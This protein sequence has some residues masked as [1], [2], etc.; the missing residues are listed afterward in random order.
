MSALAAE[1]I[2]DARYVLL[3]AI[4]RGGMGRVYRAFDRESERHVALKVLRAPARGGPSGPLSEEFAAW[5]HLRHPNIVRAYALGCAARG[6]LPPGTPYLVLEHVPGAAV[7]RAL[8]PGRETPERIESVARQVLAALAH[9]H[10]AGLVHRD[11]KPGNVL[12]RVSAGEDPRV[13]LTDFGLAAS[14]GLAREPGRLSGSLPY[15][16]P[17]AILG[18]RLDGRGD[19]YALGILLFFLVAGRLPFDARD[20]EGVVRWHLEGPPADPRAVR[21]DCPDRLARLVA[22]LTA[23]DPAIR[24]LDARAALEALGGR[25]QHRRAGPPVV[26]RR[27]AIA[28]LRLA[29]DAV[30]V[31]AWRALDL[32][33]ARKEARALAEEAGVLAQVHGAVL[34]RLRATR[35]GAGSNLARIVLR[36]LVARGPAARDLVRRYGLGERL[37]LGFFGGLP[38]WD[39]MKAEGPALASDPGAVEP[40]ARGVAVFLAESI[41]PGASVLVVEPGALR[42]PVA[43]AVVARLRAEAARRA[44]PRPAG[45]GLLLV[46]PADDAESAQAAP[47]ARR[48]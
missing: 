14:S 27:G 15:V 28:S 48:A 33:A 20:A 7:H 10:D 23:R 6:P 45:G 31:G 24:P 13:K 41:G 12:V 35:S 37:P 5:A 11:L 44:A 3:E 40:T 43:R 29:F 4:G 32:P 19:L 9:V 39:R 46:A 2:L 34:L 8:A 42:D 38:L 18:G 36:L 26:A 25:P 17:E 22:R 16:P 1:P 30:R 47:L 21:P